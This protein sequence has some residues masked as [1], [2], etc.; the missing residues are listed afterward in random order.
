MVIY[1]LF[2]PMKILQFVTAFLFSVLIYSCTK[3]SSRTT[4]LTEKKWQRTSI[5]LSYDTDTGRKYQDT[6]SQLPDYEKDD[7]YTFHSDSTYELNDNVVLN[8]SVTSL[9]LVHG[10]WYFTEN[11]SFLQIII[12]SITFFIHPARILKLTN[13]ELETENSFGN[14]KE[15]IGYRAIR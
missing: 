13:D 14:V 2:T 12:P 6:Y 5:I 15:L 1:C 11:E 10:T 3:N 4:L 8:P 9:V 7:Y